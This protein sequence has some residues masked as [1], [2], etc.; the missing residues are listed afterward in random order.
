L[1]DAIDMVFPLSGNSLRPDYALPLWQSLR[2]M[3]P[4]LVD[5]PS[6]GIL[7]IAGAS[8]GD[9]VLYLGQRAHLTLRLPQGRVA[10]ATAL[11][12][13]QLDLGGGITI[14][15]ARL[16]ALHATPAQY[17]P[18]VALGCEAEEAFLAECTTRLSEIGVNCSLVCGR[19]QMKSGEGGEIRGFSLL[20]HGLTA[21]HSL[22]IQQLG[23]GE[24]RKLGCGI[25]VPHKT[26]TAVGAA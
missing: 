20:L 6:A 19:A 14:G 21:A 26:A 3:L 2:V 13:L 17:S 11:S 4:W 23:L 24:A 9:G 25:F 18:C 10:D 8:V 16:R 22:S 7:P 12:G 5:E 1:K 15:E